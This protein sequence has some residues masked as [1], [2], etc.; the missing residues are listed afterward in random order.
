MRNDLRRQGVG[1]LLLVILAAAALPCFPIHAEETKPAE[2]KSPDAKPAPGHSVHGEAFD[3]GP[4]QAARKMPG[5]GVVRLEITAKSP[6]VKAEVQEWFN[7]GLGQIHGFWYYEA[8]RSFRQMA[9][10]DPDCAMAYWGM[11]LANVN[12]AKRAR[13]F[14]AEALKQKEKASPRERLYIEALA[15]L[16]PEEKP[17]EKKPADAKKAEKDR[18]DKYIDALEKLLYDHPDEL[19]A[20]ALLVVALWSAREDDLPITSHLAVNALLTEIFAVEPQHP[21]HHYRVHLWD[22][23]KAAKA[24]SSAAVIGQSAPAIAH[25][26]H[27]SGHIFADLERFDDAA[28]QQEAAARVDHAYMIADRILPDQIHNYAHNSEWLIRDLDHTGRVRHGLALAKNLIEMPRHPKLNTLDKGNSTAT[29][30]RKR[31]VDLL[32]RNE[33]WGELLELAQS[34]WYDTTLVDG[35]R[36]SRKDLVEQWRVLGLASYQT[37]D[38][39]MGDAWMRRLEAELAAC[40]GEITTAKNRPM[41]PVP[42]V[43]PNLKDD[44]KKQA[45]AAHKEAQ[46]KRKTAEES[47]KDDVKKLEGEEKR[48]GSVVAKLKAVRAFL[49]S[50]RANALTFL[51]TVEGPDTD[52]FLEARLLLAVGD[53][54]AA[55]KLARDEVDSHKNQVRYLANAVWLHAEAGDLQA[56]RDLFDKLLPLSSQIELDVPV[57][58]RL[59]PLTAAWGLASDWRKPVE[60]KSDVGDRPALDTLGPYLWSPPV[61]PAWS[62]TDSAGAPRTSAEFS[63]K[64][65][66]LLFYLGASCL[67]CT[68]Q[69]QAFR[70]QQPEFAKL[71]ID[72]IGLSTDTVVDL[73]ASLDKFAPESFPYPLLSDHGLAAFK[74]FRAHDDFENQPL[75]GTFLVDAKGQLRWWDIGPEPF[76]DAGFLKNEA[77]RLLAFPGEPARPVEVAPVTGTQ[78]TADAAAGS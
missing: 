17:G 23:E 5:C 47:R 57:Y 41:P 1:R 68:E 42:E 61:A 67:H 62:A 39:T 51:A 38:E 13:G 30:G 65:T 66:L 28:W 37:G 71:G 72:L 15:H 27:M 49:R 44:A 76:M 52:K 56:A 12:N 48:L 7:Q 64:P 59:A 46:E 70:K 45:E 11:A 4:R 58:A 60:A 74:A 50:E 75:H 73:K 35:S 77:V 40:R 3:E 43:D 54:D 9:K 53:R 55:L 22:H 31:L 69:L 21:S 8:E 2:A 34:R 33:L 26:W 78:A 25:M 18:S 19:E 29:Y 32:E 6:E 63:G 14:M 24:L 36:A 20:K 16:Y 10:V